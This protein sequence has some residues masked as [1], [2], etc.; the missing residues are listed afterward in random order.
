[1]KCITDMTTPDITTPHAWTWW[2]EQI[3]DTRRSGRGLDWKTPCCLLFSVL[4]SRLICCCIRTDKQTD[5]QTKDKITY[6]NKRERHL[7]TFIKKKQRSAP[8]PLGGFCQK[9]LADLHIFFFFYHLFFPCLFI[10][11]FVSFSCLFFFYP[12]WGIVLLYIKNP[13]KIHLE[14]KFTKKI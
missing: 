5:R 1:M 3:V 14:N 10:T 4:H 6:L 2:H 8:E 12:L 11:S 9:Q 13:F 7:T